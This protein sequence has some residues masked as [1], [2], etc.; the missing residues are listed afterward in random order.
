VAV[1]S[2]VSDPISANPIWQEKAQVELKAKT[3]WRWEQFRSPR[4]GALSTGQVMAAGTEVHFKQEPG[5][6]KAKLLG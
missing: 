4:S 2:R 3:P 5:D 1:H 6:Y